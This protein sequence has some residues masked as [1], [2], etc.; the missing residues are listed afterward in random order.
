MYHLLD[1]YS[2]SSVDLLTE[3]V[4]YLFQILGLILSSF[5]VKKKQGQ[6]PPTHVFTALIAADFVFLLLS[7]LS[8]TGTAS[9]VFGF[10]MNLLHGCVASI[11]LTKL[12]TEVSGQ[13]R[14]ITFGCGYG[15]GCIGSF[16]LSLIGNGNFLK[17]R[18]VLLVYFVLILL[19]VLLLYLPSEKPVAESMP[20]SP[21]YPL[22]KRMLLLAGISLLLLCSTKSMGFYFPTADLSNASVSLEY[23]RIFYAVG[24]VLAGIM[25][26]KSRKFGAVCCLSSL[27]CPFAMLVLKDNIESSLVLWIISYLFFGF[28]SVYR[29]ILFTDMAANSTEC[30]YLAGLGLMWGRCGDVIGTVLGICFSANT[31]ILVLVTSLFFIIT[32]P[33]FLSLYHKIYLPVITEKEDKET[34]LED[35]EKRYLLSPRESEVFQLIIDGRSNTEIAEALF[36]SENTVKFHMKNI[37]KKTNCSNRTSLIVL[38][39]KH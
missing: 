19:S 7:V 3:V 35:F 25:N 12:V 11:Y 10:L 15:I 21:Q 16:I 14:G 39:E 6:L 34:L 17:N 8:T 28:F 36:I 26:D 32:V 2:A 5:Y 23:S 4:G 13:Y 22:T 37:L 9:L 30:L 33:L 29:V 27:V 20:A 38:F 18:A 24:L 31:V 1:F